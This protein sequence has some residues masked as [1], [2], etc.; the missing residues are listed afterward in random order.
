M[1]SGSRRSGALYCA[2]AMT[3]LGSSFPV[4]G[5][6]TGY[7]TLTGQAVRYLVAA[8]LLSVVLRVERR[9][10]RHRTVARRD[11]PRLAALAATGL[12]GFNICLLAAL[13]AA[14]APVV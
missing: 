3:I 1:R 2:V 9:T 5:R 8:L 14:D 11:L 10:G 4:S 7:P 13:R 6:I 12:V